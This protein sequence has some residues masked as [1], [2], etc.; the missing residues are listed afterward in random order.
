MI[1]LFGKCTSIV[2]NSFRITC[3]H[4]EQGN[5]EIR[6]HVTISLFRYKTF[7]LPL[8]FKMFRHKE[9]DTIFFML[10]S[11]SCPYLVRNPWRANPS[12]LSEHQKSNLLIQRLV[13]TLLTFFKFPKSSSGFRCVTSF[14]LCHQFLFSGYCE[15]SE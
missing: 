13:L 2:H 15:N 14:A 10:A 3:M 5:L 6:K 4:K 8:R 9:R 11:S 1:W 12:R 7:L